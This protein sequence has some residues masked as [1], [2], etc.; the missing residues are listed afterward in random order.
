MYGNKRYIDEKYA[1]VIMQLAAHY[2]NTHTAADPLA[3]AMDRALETMDSYV[4]YI[5][6][7]G[8]TMYEISIEAMIEYTGSLLDSQTAFDAETLTEI[9]GYLKTLVKR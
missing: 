6:N 9:K 4:A 1:D 8:Y 2:R 3:F 7:L 5:N